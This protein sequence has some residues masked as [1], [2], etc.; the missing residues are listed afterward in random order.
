MSD[1]ITL[2]AGGSMA[3]RGVSSLFGA[4]AAVDQGQ[5]Q[6]EMYQYRAYVAA[7]NAQI[8]LQNRTYDLQTGQVLAFN[9]DLKTRTQIGT[10]EADAGASGFEI[11]GSK[12]AAIESAHELGRYNTL[13][14]VGNA[15]RRAQQDLVQSYNYTNEALMDER[16]GANAERAGRI[17]AESTLLGGA[18]SVADRWAGFQSRGVWG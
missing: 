6:N 14:I 1:P 12:S 17:N 18:T 8:A 5:H 15:N 3:L 13:Q 9:Q 7:Q 11:S 4:G 10:A 2:A 16:S